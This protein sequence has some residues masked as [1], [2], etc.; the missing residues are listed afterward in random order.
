VQGY[1]VSRPLPA[2]AV[3]KLMQQRFLFP[4]ESP[5]ES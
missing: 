4:A 3:A 5:L 1:F 2:D